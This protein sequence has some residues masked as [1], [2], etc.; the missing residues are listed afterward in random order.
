MIDIHSHVVWGLDD[1][2]ASLEE[3]TAM[4]ESAWASGTTEIVATPHFSPQYE[5]QSDLLQQRIIE[6]AERTG[7]RPQIHRGCEF[8]L[9]FDNVEQLL[10]L[11]EKYTIN[12][13]QYLLVEF[14]SAQ[15]GKHSEKI[16]DHL[17]KAGLTPIIAH[18]ERN[19]V[20]RHDLD[21]VE[22]WVDLGCLTQVTALSI[23]G[24]F[25]NSARTASVRLLERG[26]VHVI[27]SDTHDIAHRPPNLHTAFTEVQSRWGADAAEILFRDN[28]RAIIQG[29]RVP[30]GRLPLCEPVPWW[31]LWKRSNTRTG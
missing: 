8:F 26:L 14:A 31:Q 1:G 17:L 20:L 19:L 7:N 4:L 12:G 16:L 23:A 27:A 25:G 24:G 22:R 11:P 13:K 5:F 30:G 6:L 2:A 18:P 9:G 10:H 28:P 15:V 21:R 3:S 29:D